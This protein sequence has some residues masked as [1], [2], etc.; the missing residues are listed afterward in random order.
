[1]DMGT[2]RTKARPVVR[3]NLHLSIDAD[4]ASRFRAFAGHHGRTY[5]DV[6][7]EA[8]KLVTKGFAVHVREAPE[9][10]GSG[11]RPTTDGRA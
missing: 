9:G 2:K 11:E 10:E 3:V 7:S 8:V 1:M 6:F 5:S 4:V